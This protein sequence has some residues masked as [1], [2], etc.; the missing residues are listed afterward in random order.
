MAYRT[1]QDSARRCQSSCEPVIRKLKQEEEGTPAHNILVCTIYQ[2]MLDMDTMNEILETESQYTDEQIVKLAEF[3]NCL[4]SHT[5]Q[6][7]GFCTTVSLVEEGA[8]WSKLE[9]LV[10][11]CNRILAERGL[12]QISTVKT[13]NATVPQYPPPARLTCDAEWTGVTI[14]AMTLATLAGLG[15]VVGLIGLWWKRFNVLA[16]A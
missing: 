15:L 8:I 9:D 7:S 4:L 11:G 5:L 12:S 6:I 14:F 13:H 16:S 3:V 2:D 1:Q 10:D